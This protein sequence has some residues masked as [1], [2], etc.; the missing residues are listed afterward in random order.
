MLK[1]FLE[2]KE[3]GVD[4]EWRYWRKNRKGCVIGGGDTGIKEKVN[5]RL[6]ERVRK[7]WNLRCFLE[8]LEDE[9]NGFR[10]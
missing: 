4:P 5:L 9:R 6:K 7:G 10:I 2:L 1:W 3:D 8:P